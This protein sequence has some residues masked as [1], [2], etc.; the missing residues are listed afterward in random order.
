MS[1]TVDESLL[2]Y[3][4]RSGDVGAHEKIYRREPGRVFAACLR[5]MEDR[6]LTDDIADKHI[7]L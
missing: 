7:S 6:A 1:T 3:R 4:A 5:L 2:V